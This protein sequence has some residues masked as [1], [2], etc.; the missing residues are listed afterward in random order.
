MVIVYTDRTL[1]GPRPLATVA[2]EAV[3]GGA[4]RVVLREKD[5]P[6]DAR[7]ALAGELSE[8]I[9]DRLLVSDV[10]GAHRDALGRVVGRACHR[11]AD[12][13]AATRLAYVTVSPV[14]PTASKPGYGPALGLS[15]LRNWC[16]AC[17]VPVLA[18]GGVD[19]PER[20]GACVRAGAAGVAVMGAVMTAADPAAVVRAMVE[21]VCANLRW[22]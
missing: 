4:D 13:V 10:D 6:P 5:L 19:S 9:G 14:F 3:A 8:R 12:V 21:A 7:G 18:L 11:A 22:H 2:A 17:A 20:A 16:A 1:S 15:T